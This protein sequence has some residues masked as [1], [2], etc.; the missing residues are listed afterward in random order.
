MQRA[1]EYLERTRAIFQ[2]A[3]AGLTDEQW[4][5]KPTPECW[6]VAECTEHLALVEERILALVQSMPNQPETSAEELAVIQ[7]KDE[8][9]LTK[10]SSRR[11]KQL[12]PPDAVPA[13]RWPQDELRARFLAVRDRTIA[14]ASLADGA[15]HT[16]VNPHFALGPLTGYQ[17]LLFVAAHSDRHLKQME[18]VKA[19]PAFPG[20]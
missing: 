2:R 16:R 3:T 17:W 13:N 8:F 15:L 5:F 1:I 6:S 18:E 9:I 10:V 19:D 4:H 7:K 11:R 12:A 14:L 20:I